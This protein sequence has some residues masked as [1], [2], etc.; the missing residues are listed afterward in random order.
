MTDPIE[1]VKRWDRALDWCKARPMLG[2]YI[3]LIG[4]GNFILMLVNLFVE[5]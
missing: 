5:H 3:A 1:N 4:T 2:W